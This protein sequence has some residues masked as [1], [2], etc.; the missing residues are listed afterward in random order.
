M[1]TRLA[2]VAFASAATIAAPSLAATVWDEGTDGDLGVAFQDAQSI[3]FALGVNRVVGESHFLGSAGGLSDWDNDEFSF[4]IPSGAKLRA[5]TLRF[6]VI[7]SASASFLNTA[8]QI[9]EWASAYPTA[10]ELSAWLINEPDPG[11]VINPLQISGLD[12]SAPRYVWLDQGILSGYGTRWAYQLDFLVT[13]IPA[14]GTAV[15]LALGLA[16]LGRGRRRG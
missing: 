1:R 10:L 16:A 14:P 5:I 13:A 15:L 9:I 12:L 7:D 4:T 11:A 6:G 2:A 3:D 8:Y